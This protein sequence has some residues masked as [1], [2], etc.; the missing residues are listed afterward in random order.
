[1][2]HAD[3]TYRAI[4][5]DLDGTLLPMDIDEFMT[6][7]FTRI[8]R[9][10]A[11]KGM[12]GQLFMAALKAGTKAMATHTDDRTNEEAFWDE[13][14]PAYETGVG[15]TL[16]SEE[17]AQMRTLADEFYDQDFPHIGDG[18]TPNP[19]AARVVN[20]LAQKGYPLVLA[21]MPMF[22]LRAVEHR[23]RWA[24]VD[25]AVFQ[26]ITCYQNAKS[27]KP[28]QTYFAEVL[29]ALGVP[30]ADVLMVG[31]NTMEDFAVL[32]LGVDGYLITDCLL[33]PIGFDISTIK[34]GSLEEF[35]EWAEALPPCSDP[36]QGIRTDVIPQ[37]DTMRALEE[38]AV[39]PI[40]LDE[41]NRRAAVVAGAV[42]GN[43]EPGAASR[44][45]V[46]AE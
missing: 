43:H 29:A 18:F 44:L 17:R 20:A 6:A 16:T 38:N 3:R 12:D 32:D 9:F 26:R 45:R 37:A 8:G 33:D 34:H 2:T 21:T 31:N 11:A 41:A 15:R 40:D 13:F 28:K 19:A 1:M 25:P 35:A 30:G 10:M 42:A 39:V 5:F 22:P 24:G 23:L 7:Y 14:F 36:A 46:S 27:V 4:C